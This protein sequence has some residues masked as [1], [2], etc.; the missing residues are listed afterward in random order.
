MYE[1]DR[2]TFQENPVNNQDSLNKQNTLK[3]HVMISHQ[4]A[5][6]KSLGNR[7]T[8]R[9]SSEFEENYFTFF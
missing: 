2:K 8:N 1:R 5:Q 7:L 3:Y 4:L 9:S 6:F